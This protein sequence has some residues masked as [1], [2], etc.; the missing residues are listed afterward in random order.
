[1][2]RF[3]Q[4]W[5]RWDF[6]FQHSRDPNLYHVPSGHL[7]VLGR[8]LIA[9]CIHNRA[10]LPGL[11]FPGKELKLERYGAPGWFRIIENE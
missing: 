11:R 8:D 2:S 6:V 4:V 7:T 1:M 10:H 5:C 9:E 3:Q